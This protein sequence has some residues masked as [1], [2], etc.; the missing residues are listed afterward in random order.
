MKKFFTLIAAVA[1]AASVNAQT[2]KVF[3]ENTFLLRKR[4]VKEQ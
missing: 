4:K 3:T 1:L 2:A